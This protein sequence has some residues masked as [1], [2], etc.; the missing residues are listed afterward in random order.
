MS[1][2][3]RTTIR[4]NIAARLL[5]KFGPAGSVNHMLRAVQAAIWT[6]PNAPQS[7]VSVMDNGQKRAGYRDALALAAGKL[8]APLAYDALIATRQFSDEIV[9]VRKL[10]RM[11]HILLRSH[12][13]T[14]CDIFGDRR[15]E[16]RRVLGNV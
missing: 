12:R 15:M 4:K 1:D 10:S 14:V 13:R 3:I 8:D 2:S 5:A 7:R 11:L 6:P 16:K 9:G